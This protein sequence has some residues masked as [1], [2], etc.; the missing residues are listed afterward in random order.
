MKHAL[1]A[2]A[3]FACSGNPHPEAAAPPQGSATATPTPAVAATAAGKVVTTKFHSDA[4]GVDKDVV[5]YLPAGYDAAPDRHWPVF[6]YLHGLTGDET[7]WV[8]GGELDHAAD[9]RG[10]QAIVVMP[11]GDNNFYVDSAMPI[12]YDTCLK[13]GTGLFIPQQNKQK[14]CVRHS[15]YETYITKDLVGW[16]DHAYRTIATRDGR[17][18]AGLSMGGFGALMLAMRHPDLFSA[19]ASHSGVDSLLFNGPVPYQKGH[20]EL[21][22]DPKLWGAG[23]GPMGTWVRGLFGKDITAW[24]AYDPGFLV[25]KLAPGQLALYLDCGTEDDFLL[26]NQAAYLHDL[27]LAKHIDHEFFLGPGHHNFEFWK[28]RVGNSLAFLSAHVAKPS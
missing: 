13:D 22:Q 26:N 16:V 3:L 24:R 5:V 10:L 9:A 20:V 4:L 6:Y 15:A 7:N 8:Q 12:D 25:D 14:T 17:G 23:V 18:I 27:L 1:L 11:D 28:T 2:C 21:L 19:A